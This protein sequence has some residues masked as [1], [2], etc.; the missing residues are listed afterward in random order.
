MAG[1]KMGLEDLFE[2]GHNSHQGDQLEDV[3]EDDPSYI[4]WCIDQD[5]VEFDEE[6]MKLIHER[7]IA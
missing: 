4:A 1:Y 3:I 5:V 7:K 6:A 2:F